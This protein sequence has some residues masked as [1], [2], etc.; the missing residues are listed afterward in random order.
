MDPCTV[1]QVMVLRSSI[2]PCAVC[3]LLALCVR[4]LEL[5]TQDSD[6][7]R[8]ESNES[9]PVQL[10]STAA[11]HQHLLIAGCGSSELG[12]TL[13]A[14]GATHVSIAAWTRC[15]KA[16]QPSYSSARKLAGCRCQRWNKKLSLL[17]K[18]S[19]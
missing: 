16:S 6:S 1:R 4:V 8:D 18:G 14:A 13:S 11:R 17:Y 12:C 9:Q 19:S 3:R 2:L 7:A 15:N 10:H 5:D